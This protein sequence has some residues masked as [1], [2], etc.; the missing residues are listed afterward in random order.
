MELEK[1]QIYLKSMHKFD[2][3]K[4]N[5]DLAEDV[6]KRFERIIPL[7]RKPSNDLDIEIGSLIMELLQLCNILGFD[8]EKVLKEKLKF[9]L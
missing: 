5:D 8:L 2:R 9:G 7:I 1:I 6:K 4:T 3:K